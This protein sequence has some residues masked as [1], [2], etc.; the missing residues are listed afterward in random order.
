M[1]TRKFRV[2][3]HDGPEWVCYFYFVEWSHISLGFHV[4]LATPNIEIHLPFGFI[5]IG[6]SPKPIR[7]ERVFWETE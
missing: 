7:A 3:G 6:K 5:R 4:D 1:L 2:H